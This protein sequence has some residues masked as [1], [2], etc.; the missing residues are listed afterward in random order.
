[1][2]ARGFGRAIV[3]WAWLV[4]GGCVLAGAPAAEPSAG[5]IYIRD[6]PFHVQQTYHCG[7]ASLAAVLNYWGDSSSPADIATAIYSPRLRGTLGVD[8][9]RYAQGRHLRADMRRGSLDELNRLIRQNVPAIAFL[10]LGN[11]WLPVPHFVVVVGLDPEASAV[12][13]YN[14]RQRNSLIPY[15]TFVQAWAKTNYW[16]LVVQ[17]PGEA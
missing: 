4:S 15:D 1:M 7:P 14:G 9:W 10:N 17:R 2:M 11:E 5:A 8:M 12:I 13:T 6:V 16:T 3:L